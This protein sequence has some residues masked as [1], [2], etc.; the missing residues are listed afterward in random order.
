MSDSNDIGISIFA[1]TVLLA[2]L[3]VGFAN[4]H[5]PVGLVLFSFAGAW[6]CCGIF[7]FLAWLFNGCK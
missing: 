5:K 3:F 7:V 4:V 2:T 1:W 6:F